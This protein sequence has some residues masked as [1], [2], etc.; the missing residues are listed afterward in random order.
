MNR[1]YKGLPSTSHQKTEEWLPLAVRRVLRRASDEGYDAVAFTSGDLASQ[2]V[3]MPQGSA[4]VF[5]DQ[6]L[7]GVLKREVGIPKKQGTE[8]FFFDFGDGQET[9]AGVSL[10]PELK[11]KLSGPQKLYSA[12]P[13]AVGAG[14]AA[15]AAQ[16]ED[17]SLEDKRMEAIRRAMSE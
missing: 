7:P 8:E 3:S 17:K 16:D 1:A 5:Y 14:A 15:G 2:V 9:M 13:L 12:I 11:K 10:T 6:K 4:T